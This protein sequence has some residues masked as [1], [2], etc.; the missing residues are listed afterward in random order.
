MKRFY[1]ALL[2]EWLD[3]PAVCLAFGVSWPLDMYYTKITRRHQ[4]IKN[5]CSLHGVS[6]FHLLDPRA[7]LNTLHRKRVTQTLPDELAPFRNLD[8]L[9]LGP[10]GSSYRELYRLGWFNAPKVAAAFQI[11]HGQDPKERERSIKGAIYWDLSV[12]SLSQVHPRD[13]CEFVIRRGIGFT[14]PKSLVRA[15][16]G[17][18]C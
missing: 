13:F 18:A 4:V 12:V 7:F 8:L 1:D 3:K 11:K 16:G 17:E 14:L 9:H 2:G 10:Y 5:I 15:A 6:Q